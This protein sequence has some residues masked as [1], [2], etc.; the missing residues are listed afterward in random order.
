MKPKYKPLKELNDKTLKY[1]TKVKVK[2]KGSPQQSPNK[3]RYQ[4]L[5][6]KDD[7]GFIIKGVLFDSDIEKYAEAL[8]CNREYELSNAM[9]NVV[10]PQHASR[11]NEY[12][13][14]IN[15]QAQINPSPINVT[16]PVPQYQPLAAI[17]CDPF[18]IE[19]FGKS[20]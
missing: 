19:L 11:S 14:V 4:Q 18:N 15:S 20:L 12:S 2:F 9:I 16:D 5:L 1:K 6:L 3:P 17:P 7:E 8:E 13:I 10:L